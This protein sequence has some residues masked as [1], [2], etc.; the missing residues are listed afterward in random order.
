LTDT[1]SK[2]LREFY[3][4]SGITCEVLD[5]SENVIHA[6]D[7]EFGRINK[8]CEYNQMR[9]LAAF[10][11]SRFS[12]TDFAGTSGYGYDDRGRDRIEEVFAR[13]FG[14]EKAFVR[15][16]ISS[17][18]QAIA[19]ALYGILRPGDRLLSVTGRPYDTLM[20]TIG[21]SDKEGM[22]SLR[23]FGIE[24]GQVDFD[25]NGEISYDNIK[26]SIDEKTRMVYIQK[27]RGYT[28]RRSLLISDIRKI[29][30]TV[31]KIRED[32]I[33]LV[34]NCYGEFVENEEP[35]HAG[36]DICAG[37]LIK[38]PG[39][40]HCL[41]GGYLAGRS[42]LVEMA[43]CRLTAPGIGSHI[44]PSLGMN[45]MVAQGLFM[46]PHA[47]SQAIKGAT[48]AAAFFAGAGC[49]VFPKADEF[50]GDIVQTVVFDQEEELIEFCQ[51]VQSSSPVDSFVKPEPWDMPGYDHQVI[52]A[53]GNFVS[54]SS[55][56]LSC[57]A[58]IKSPFT[59]YMQGGLVFEQTKYACM[60]AASKMKLKTP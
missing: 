31:K 1:I 15:T 56:E 6:L 52:M 13:I 11:E 12:D 53:A 36:A 57:D 24:Y 33:V 29:V 60:I 39:G 8:I 7:S 14:A 17:G 2:G 4:S 51:A 47:V 30:N 45:R 18:T 16:Q 20:D 26:A 22:G 5:L 35:C 50:R 28:E 48:F 3:L 58:P 25:G 54:G 41:T 32:I 21:I 9:V 42:D 38:N 46:A 27:S 34:D 10:K 23:E 55:I 19:M 59:A 44:G 49:K 43:A 40:G 37:S